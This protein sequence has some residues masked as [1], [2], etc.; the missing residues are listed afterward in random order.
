MSEHRQQGDNNGQWQ[1]PPEAPAE[2]GKFRIFILIQ[3][4]N[5]RLQRHAAFGAGSRRRLT[6]FRVHR[7]G[8]D[9]ALDYGDG[10]ILGVQVTLGI[11]IELGLALDTAKQISRPSQIGKNTLVSRYAHATDGILLG[12]DHG[13]RM[14]HMTVPGLVQTGIAQDTLPVLLTCVMRGTNAGVW[15]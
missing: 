2:I 15:A 3:M 8:V 10:F 4:G 14:M 13:G 7:T 6:D 11:K 1:R 9:R 5:H 12:P